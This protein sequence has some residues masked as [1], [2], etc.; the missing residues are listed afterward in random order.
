M[1]NNNEILQV[2]YEIAMSIGNSLDLNKMLKQAL[3]TYL[4]KL[5]CTAVLLFSYNDFD[6]KSN[7]ELKYKLPYSLDLNK[8]IPELNGILSNVMLQVGNT[9]SV[10]GK[11][12]NEQNYYLFDLPD[13]G[14]IILLRSSKFD[15][16]IINSLIDINKK[17]ASSCLACYNNEKLKLSERKYRELGELLPEMVCETDTKGRILFANKYALE[18]MGYTKSDLDRGLTIFDYIDPEY[19]DKAKDYFNKALINSAI[20]P[21][22]YKALKKDGTIFPVIVYSNHITENS[23][24]VGI[25]YI[26]VDI[27]KRKEYE[28]QLHQYAEQLELTL[29]GNEAGLWQWDIN[30]GNINYSARW[31]AILG[32][33]QKASESTITKHEKRI[34]KN[35]LKTVTDTLSKHLKGESAIYQVEY[36]IRNKKKEYI[37]VQDTGKITEYDQERKPIKMVGTLVNIHTRKQNELAL[38]QNYLQQELLSDIA[39][40]LNTLTSFKNIINS[41]LEKIGHHIGVSRVYIFEDTQEGILTSN[42]YEWCNIDVESQMNELQEIPYDYIPSWKPMLLKEGR[43]YSEN[44][45]ELPQDLI[46]ILEPQ[47]IK[48]IIVYPLYVQGKFLG[49]IGFD[50]CLRIKKWNKSEL[51]LLRTISGIIAN[52]YERK[53]SEQ[54]LKESEAIN[55]AILESIPDKLFH[56]SKN[57]TILNYKGTSKEHSFN[58]DLVNKNVN[59]VFPPETAIQMLSAIKSCIKSG[60]TRI[61]YSVISQ[62]ETVFYEARL[63]K[64]N[65]NEVITIA[66]DISQRKK[67]ESELKAERDKA[68]QANQ[69]KSEFLANMSHEIRTPMNAILG[70]SEALY[71]KV[72]NSQHKKMLKSVLSSGN[73]LLSLLNDILDLSKIDAGKLV[74]SPQPMDLIYI[75]EEIKLLFQDKAHKKGIDVRVSISPNFPK[76]ILLDEIRVKQ[77]LFNLVGNA[78]KFTH[79]GYIQVKIGFK[80]TSND[81]GVL[82]L[83]IVDTGIGIPLNQQQMIFEAFQQQSGQ[84]NRKYE[85]AGLGLAISKRLIEKM[86]GTI[87]LKSKIQQGSTFAVTIPEVKITDKIIHLNDDASEYDNNIHFNTGT[88]LVVDDVIV[89]IDTIENYLIELGL[90]V[91]SAD[92]GEIALEILKY[93]KP[94]LILM[95][96]RMPGMDGYQVT[97]KIK[98]NPSLNNIPVVAY[99]ASVFGSEE[100]ENYK[101]FDDKLF[102]PVRKSDLIKLLTKYLKYEEYEVE[103]V[104]ER[105]VVVD[106]KLELSDTTLN[107][108]PIIIKELEEKFVP[109]WKEIKGSL[110][111]F[112]I[113]EFAKNIESFADRFNVNTLQ[114]WALQLLDDV[115]NL[116]LESIKSNLIV[117]P[118]LID[119]LKEYQMK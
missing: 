71:L 43:V 52:G 75:V 117:F 91:N 85:G 49:F 88:I 47:N 12:M 51:E 102:K 63:A 116:D 82:T 100:N 38:H 54:S 55:R 89:N 78:L 26:M 19:K 46:D 112:K 69:A 53:I 4:S 27:S 94:D 62:S 28:M 109:L 110:V 34:H 84:L 6:N 14:I 15:D 25:R 96:L 68:N 31:R 80:Q 60:F 35:D 8:D 56:F 7:F 22:D 21:R 18:K 97:Q 5:N 72:E 59:E 86:G 13:Y 3:L 64:M 42:T 1:K 70:F 66:R 65:N 37:W 92:N 119:Q 114:K 79:K 48:S 115:E 111:L 20:P 61:E 16:G 103:K 41:I 77:V 108:L 93:N 101:I 10:Q 24:N 32:E 2:F 29:L 104:M 40:E 83:K 95:D 99:T 73:L 30:S 11:L 39:L 81:K 90:K 57:G 9:T 106:E 58:I 74:V 45:R 105:T 76:A 33:S 67:Y 113:E 44:I 23:K 50:E 36:R 98:S 87:S 17:L 118:E 107:N